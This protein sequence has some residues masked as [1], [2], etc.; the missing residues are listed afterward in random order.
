MSEEELD[1]Y[2]KSNLSLKLENVSDDYSDIN[3]IKVS[4]ILKGEV[5]SSETVITNY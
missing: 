2:I 4:L 3:L 1:K 5:I